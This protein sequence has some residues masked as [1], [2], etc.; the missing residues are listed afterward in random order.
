MKK[1]S[2]KVAT[3]L[4]AGVFDARMTAGDGLFFAAR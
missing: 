2:L 3:C 1:I 4:V